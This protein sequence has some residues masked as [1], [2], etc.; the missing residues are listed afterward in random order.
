V[1]ITK[2]LPSVAFPLV[3]LV[4]SGCALP[5]DLVLTSA[6][7]PACSADADADAAWNRVV[8]D[9]LEVDATT[10]GFVEL[11]VGKAERGG[12]W[13]PHTDVWYPVDGFKAAVSG[14]LQ[15][16]AW[17]TGDDF[18]WNLD[19]A[20][21]PG[22]SSQERV[23]EFQ[24]RFDPVTFGTGKLPRIHCE[25]APESSFPD[26]AGFWF[27]QF[28]LMDEGRLGAFGPW[29]GDLNPDHDS[30]AAIPELHP[31][32]LTWWRQTTGPLDSIFWLLV[33]QDSINQYNRRESYYDDAPFR[34]RFR[35]RDYFDFDGRPEPAGWKPWA[36]GPIHAQYRIAFE[37]LLNEPAARFWIVPQAKLAV[38]SKP[39]SDMDDGFDH[40]LVV[41]GREILRATEVADEKDTAVRVAGLCRTEDGAIRGF[42]EVTTWVGV[43]K[44][45][46]KS[47]FHFLAVIRN[48]GVPRP[49]RDRPIPSRPAVVEGANRD[50]AKE[51]KTGS[52]K[53]AMLAWLDAVPTVRADAVTCAWYQV[54]QTLEQPEL[55]PPPANLLRAVTE[56]EITANFEL[57]PQERGKVRLEDASAEEQLASREA[58][59]TAR[60]EWDVQLACFDPGTKIATREDDGKGA[61]D[62]TSPA[63]VIGK[64]AG[65]T[66]QGTLHLSIPPEY[67]SHLVHATVTAT[68]TDAR[69]HVAKATT[70]L[71]NFA[72]ASE[73]DLLA[74]EVSSWLDHS[75]HDPGLTIV[76]LILYE[77][78]SDGVI[79]LPEL[80]SYL[81]TIKKR[82]PTH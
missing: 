44:P 64:R 43:D 80:R 1:R 77:I 73:R 38:V 40:R 78:V 24:E 39:K 50:V 14:P 9:F 6:Q 62:S 68:V 12:G 71:W 81:R 4:V 65:R 59:A 33:M 28:P 52:E 57:G 7:I 69:G 48:G 45:D 55:A 17:E 74:M 66:P 79:T 63:V 41:D 15:F 19:V 42:L 32:E 61:A 27:T 67:A 51:R 35:Q 37:V 46:D 56:W 29:V 30:K 49:R 47:G 60:V 82:A 16:I 8:T 36:K 25:V 13:S 75:P 54:A 20:V 10:P 34:N 58:L 31:V 22:S 21:E 72:L 26:R 23:Q 53:P 11:G 3:S 70:E 5:V 76:Q 18:D 2:R